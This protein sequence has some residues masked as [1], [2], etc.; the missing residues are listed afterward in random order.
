M[1]KAISNPGRRTYFNNP[2]IEES[3]EHLPAALDYPD[4][5][6]FRAHLVDHLH[7]NS[8]TTRKRMAGY[9]ANRFSVNGLMNLDL[10]RAIRRF[11]DSQI[12]RE[13]LYFE[14]IQSIP[15][16]QEIAVRWLAELPEHGTDRASLVSFLEM[17]LGGRSI[18][19]VAKRSLQA[20][21]EFGKL[22]SPKLSYYCPIWS[23]PPLEALLYVLARL[24][25]DRTM[26]RVEMFLNENVIRAMLWP[27]ATIPELLKGAEK[28]GHI[29]KI[30]RLDQ[31]HQFTLSSPG[32]ERM[33]QL[34]AE[35]GKVTQPDKEIPKQEAPPADGQLDLF[36]IT[37]KAKKTQRKTAKGRKRNVR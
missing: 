10:G 22:A 2:L 28:T 18:R 17:W 11:G 7:F 32:A 20:F 13:I 36:G 30:S 35:E 3:L 1:S 25:P 23:K 16:L 9:I 21:K 29:S 8:L 5:K 26:V 12:G 31:Y 19:E 6:D 33:H 15:L 14:Y 27:A 4:S 37:P 24:Y 34:L